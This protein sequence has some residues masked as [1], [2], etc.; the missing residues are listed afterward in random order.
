[1]S[2]EFAKHKYLDTLLRELPYDKEQVA[3]GRIY[4]SGMLARSESG[5]V[6][7]VT[8]GYC[9]VFDSG[10]IQDAVQ[11]VVEE[12]VRTPPTLVLVLRAPA[13]LLS[14][15]R[16]TEL[17][18]AMSEASRPFAIATRPHPIVA[19]PNLQ[20]RSQEEKFLRDFVP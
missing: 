9:L 13:R 12:E 6:R 11:V 1:M 5:V 19:P 18:Q 20:F 8:G 2:S 15:E 3:A 7:I 4:M 16:W 10:D 14:F 17:D